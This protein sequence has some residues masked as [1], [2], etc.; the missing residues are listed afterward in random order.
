MFL[1]NF[2]IMT[3]VLS[4]ALILFGM[5]IFAGKPKDQLKK[6]EDKFG[7]EDSTQ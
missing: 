5:I 4:P 6:D 3:F 2:L 1:R 7:A